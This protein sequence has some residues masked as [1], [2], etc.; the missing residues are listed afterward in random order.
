MRG[1]ETAF[2]GRI[3]AGVT[4]E[5]LNVLAIISEASGLLD[6]ILTLNRGQLSSW[7]EKAMAALDRIRRQIG[8]DTELSERLNSFVHSLDESTVR[9]E[10]NDVLDQAA[11][12]M[13]RA[14]RL[15]EVVLRT[16]HA[17]PSPVISRN[18]LQLQIGLAGAEHSGRGLEC[19]KT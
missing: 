1:S 2:I 6:D 10:I 7:D 4:H 8:R 11:F 12:L 13:Q 16:R 19:F 9:V 18:P 14:A 5:G 3:T 15:E 17:N